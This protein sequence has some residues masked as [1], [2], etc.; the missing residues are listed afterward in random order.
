MNFVFNL[1]LRSS[2]V[3]TP[4][5]VWE[6]QDRG[7]WVVIEASQLIIL[8]Q[9]SCGFVNMLVKL[10]QELGV[11]TPLGGDKVAGDQEDGSEEWQKDGG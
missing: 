4:R 3:Q 10:V 11:C 6:A 7:L 5:V 8:R 1:R 9:N 2:Q